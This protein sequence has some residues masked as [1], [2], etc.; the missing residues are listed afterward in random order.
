MRRRLCRRRDRRLQIGRRNPHRR[1]GAATPSFAAHSEKCRSSARPDRC[2]AHRE[3][4]GMAAA[5]AV[6]GEPQSSPSMSRRISPASRRSATISASAKVPAEI[7]NGSAVESAS[8]HAA[9]SA[10]RA[11]I[12]ISAD[13]S[14]TITVAGRSCRTGRPGCARRSPRNHMAV[15]PAN[16][17]A[18]ISAC[19]P[20]ASHARV[21]P[22]RRTAARS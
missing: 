15:A 12:A 10:R 14:T 3:A 22:V 2:P 6:T 9:A 1:T 20:A 17:T 13:V 5:A 19:R 7:D 4:S 11:A 18:S 16:R 21:P 8:V